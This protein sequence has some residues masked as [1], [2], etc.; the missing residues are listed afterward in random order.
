[1]KR[2]CRKKKCIQGLRQWHR[3]SGQGMC[4]PSQRRNATGPATRTQL[5]MELRIIP[6][7]TQRHHKHPK[8]PL[9]KC[10]TNPFVVQ[11]VHVSTMLQERMDKF[12]H[13]EHAV[14]EA[15]ERNTSFCLFRE[16]KIQTSSRLL[17]A[18]TNALLS[19]TSL[20][21]ANIGFCGA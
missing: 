16:S 6:C 15:R 3:P 8:Q 19:F 20:A 21:L 1:M 7:N 11:Q 2:R 9:C 17:R 18:Y 13:S 5:F 4:C 14:V 12:L 10:T